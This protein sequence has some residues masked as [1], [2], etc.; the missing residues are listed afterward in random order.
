ML[1][2]KDGEWKAAGV[3]TNVWGLKV[4]RE[5]WSGHLLVCGALVWLSLMSR[6]AKRVRRAHRH[7]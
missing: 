5:P 1:G 4:P 7:P 6:G 2:N 3:S